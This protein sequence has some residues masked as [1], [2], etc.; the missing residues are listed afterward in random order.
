LGLS[1]RQDS[2]PVLPIHALAKMYGLQDVW[3]SRCMG[4]QLPIEV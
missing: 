1:A 2:T 4:T 3:A